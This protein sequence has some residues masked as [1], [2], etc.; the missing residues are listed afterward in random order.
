MTRARDNRLA[1]LAAALALSLFAFAIARDAVD[2]WIAATE[3]PVTLSDTSTEI[4]DRNGV[5]LRAF[6][7]EDGLWRLAPGAV[8][9]R[10]VAMLIRYE[11]K[12]FERHRGVD[13][14]A[15]LRAAAQALR[16][17]EVV[18]GGSTLTMQV[19]RLIEDGPTGRWAGKLRQIRLALAL[20][21]GVSKD[22]ILELYLTH[23][24]YGG[25]L[26][27]IRAAALAWFGK[28]P[29][30]LTPAQSALLVALPQA[31]EARRPD[32]H[33]DAA[34]DARNRVLDR[35]L[36]QGVLSA[37]EV[38]A[39]KR[40]PMPVQQRPFPQLAAHLSDR[41]RAADPGVR[42]IDLTLDAALQARLEPLVATA[43]RQVGPR[44]SSALIVADHAT[45]EILASVGSAGYSDARQGFVDMTR[46]L[47][48]PGS[49][50]KPLVYGLAF[51][52]GL[53]HPE[54]LISDTPV[55]FGRYAPRNFDGQFRGDLRVREALQL[56]LNI[57]VVRLTEALGPA[58]VMVAVIRAGARPELQG[59]PGLALSLGGLGISLNDLT[60]LYAAMAQGGQGAV[61]HHRVSDDGEQTARVISRSAAWHVADILRGVPPPAGAPRGLAYKTGTSYGHRDAWA[62]GFDGRHVIG[63]WLGR[64]DGTPVPGAFGG[65]L[66][67]P[68]LFEAFG[69]LKPAFEPLPPPPPETLIVG[70]AELPAP[71]RRFRPREA[72]FEGGVDAFRLLFPPD[73]ARI[74]SGGGPITVKIG[75]GQAPFSLLANGDP[76]VT[77]VHMREVELPYPGAGFTRLVV[78]DA[79]GRGV[80]AEIRVD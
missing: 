3:L 70:A 64:A 53:A 10:F 77:G 17:G 43:A 18:S 34:R 9:P 2:R 73:G 59:A 5:L 7:V 21:R 67:A 4:R 23:A 50:L 27:G 55:I 72:V 56:S 30:R 61:L 65:A 31:P 39:A 37:A 47:R 45:G 78:L 74:A 20:E 57:P 71:L 6:P 63:V 52:R 42:V 26:E 29:S 68:V 54:T 14:R 28:E 75:G 22:R 16:H 24:P 51:D 80:R 11:D 76:L 13:P 58:R 60:Q 40:D 25:N 48:S 15:L 38:H 46:A 36:R 32:R 1:F 44:V 41:S 35:M 49:T 69:R 19:A 33:P 79:A 8:D 66:A 62:F 12:R